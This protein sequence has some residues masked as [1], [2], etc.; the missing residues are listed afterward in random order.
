MSCFSKITGESRPYVDREQVFHIPKG[1]ALPLNKDHA[2]GLG[3]I[4]DAENDGTIESVAL[5][6]VVAIQQ[7]ALHDLHRLGFLT[8]NGRIIQD[9][10]N[11]V[12]D[13]QIEV[14][15][16]ILKIAD[17]DLVLTQQLVKILHQDI[18]HLVHLTLAREWKVE[19]SLGLNKT[20][21]EDLGIQSG[22]FLTV[23][24]NNF[25]VIH[26]NLF[27]V[28]YINPNSFPKMEESLFF[29]TKVIIS[30]SKEAL[31]SCNAAEI[32]SVQMYVQN[33]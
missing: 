27:R 32:G 19:G 28:F 24:K 10:S 30:G 12:G 8:G 25:S 11:K 16:G 26:E 1:G 5:K 4:L 9:L 14:F 6:K 23:D 20:E 29:K 7:S 33:L 21:F 18:L 15:D 3:N 17:K 13:S 31:K 22:K 2:S